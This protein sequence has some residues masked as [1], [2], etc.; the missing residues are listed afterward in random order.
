MTTFKALVATQDDGKF[1]AAF[2]QLEL[3][4]LPAAEVLVRVSYSSLNY[5]DGLAV[6]GKPGVIR[7]FP[8]VPGIDFAGVVEKSSSYQFKPGDKVVV[9]GGGTSETLWGGYAQF[10]RIDAEFIVPLPAGMTLK[11]AMGVGTA[12]FTAMQATMALEEHGLRPGGREVIVTGAA[13]GVGSAAVAILARLG[14][15][16]VASSGRGA[17]L[18]DYLRKL[19]AHEIV[20][21][22]VLA[23][24][25]KRPL[26]N[27]RWAAA[28]D[29]VGGDALAGLLRSMA[30]GGS[31]ASCGL[32]G[33]AA[34][35]T[36][37]L[38]FI[39]RGVNLL[40]I[41]SVH[42]PNPRRREIWLRIVRD[43]PLD[44]LDSMIEVQ[45]LERVL[46]LGEQILA[47]KIRGRT[48]IDVNA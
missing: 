4:S 11:Q 34:F 2:R 45:P 14:Y 28:I 3:E 16:V 39:L 13:G 1:A 26:E 31:V 19:G 40:G 33:G 48:V 7:K 8:M 27:E 18:G 6:T 10:A 38:P 24:P 9:T 30:P 22:A 36:T 32:A 5:K 20:D 42:V 21:R 41:N 37:V 15:K 44:L 17:E 12:G 25:S 47:G 23:A 29:N 46:E 35:G 43:L